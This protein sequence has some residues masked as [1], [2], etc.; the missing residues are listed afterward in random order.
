[1]PIPTQ[2]LMLINS[3]VRGY[4]WFLIILAA[5]FIFLFIK[6]INTKI[7]R[8]YWDSLKLKVPIFGP[9]I[10]KLT[11]SR[12]TRIT[13]VLIGSGVPLFDVLGLAARGVGNVVV[14]RIIENIKTSV[15]EGR[16]IADPM[17][18]SGLFPP[19]VVQMTSVGEQTGKL[20]ELLLEVS[21]Y[22]DSQIDYTVTNLVTLIEPILILV[23]GGVVL[24][25]AL[26]IFLPM[27]NLMQLFKR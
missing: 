26:G 25:M 21:D 27:W 6:L 3:L 10:L 13:S 11:M 18:V 14:S 2:L 20:D 22:Y 19:I 4:W 8:F 12:F 23:F 17:K 5:I 24:F 16:G 1:L 15:S 7:G 9:L